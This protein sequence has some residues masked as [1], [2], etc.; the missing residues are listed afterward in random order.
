VIVQALRFPDNGQLIG[1]TVVGHGLQARAA[2][3]FSPL[4]LY[5][6]VGVLRAGD[7]D[8][9]EHEARVELEAAFAA[10][11]DEARRAALQAQIA[12]LEAHGAEARAWVAAAGA[13]F[14]DRLI[15]L[16]ELEDVRAGASA[17]ERKLVQAR[18]QVAQ[19]E[20][21]RTVGAARGAE[22]PPGEL[23]GAYADAAADLARAEARVRAGD[24]WQIDVTAGVI[25]SSPTSPSARLDWY[26]I[27]E[28]GFNIGGIGRPGRAERYARAREEEVGR[29]PYEA[30]ARLRQ[31]RDALAAAREQARGELALIER[32]LEALGSTRRVLEQSEAPNVV[33]Q[34]EKLALDRMAIEAERAYL[35]AYVDALAIML[36]RG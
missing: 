1:G 2:L 9:R 11:D 28:L 12:F 8:C 32:D 22:R 3:S 16:V 15:T 5:K 29:A 26:G 18:G 36:A 35:R 6:G 25:P 4:D 30:A 31:H 24:P 17:L 27:V 34:R 33:Q 14:A 7:A 20:V 10:R 21:R 19:I 23:A 13:R